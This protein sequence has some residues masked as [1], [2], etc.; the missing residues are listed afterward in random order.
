MPE[1]HTVHRLAMDLNDTLGGA[2]V[3]ATSPQG[4]FRGGADLLDGEQ[5]EAAEAWGK[6]LF[7]RFGGGQLLH[8]H[9]GLIGKFRRTALTTEPRD[10]IRLRLEND[11]VAWQLTGPARCDL[12]DPDEQRS[13]CAKLG[14]DP[15]RP[16]TRITKFGAK[17]AATHK[18]IGAVLLDQSVIAGIGN[19]YRAEILFLCGIAPQRPA[20]RLSA[21]EVEAIWTTTKAQLRRGVELNRIV[22][23]S[24]REIGK[25]LS[26]IRGDDRLYVYH[27]SNCRRCGTELR[28]VELGGRPLQYCPT[29]QP[30]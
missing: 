5:L 8:V 30:S 17:L 21:E 23:T 9:L 7:C 2:P 10:T 28:T 13:I 22:T 18:P 12:I 3:R 1:G 4:R 6:Y 11:R 15:L 25:P 16:N 24:P 26:R 20:S 29:C 19:V 27:R 14:V